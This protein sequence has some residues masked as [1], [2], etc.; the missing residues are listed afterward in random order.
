[1]NG[2]LSV[3][4]SVNMPRHNPV[5]N[6]T[7]TASGF[8]SVVLPGYAPPGTLPTPDQLWAIPPGARNAITF[9]TTYTESGSCGPSPKQ[10][11]L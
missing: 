8:V 10:Y 4:T 11:C 9:N 7:Y 1:M 6:T 3:G 2:G 5:Y